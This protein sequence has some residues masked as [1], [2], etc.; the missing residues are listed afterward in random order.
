MFAV[1]ETF[2]CRPQVGPGKTVS[3]QIGQKGPGFK[4]KKAHPKMRLLTCI[5]VLLGCTWRADAVMANVNV[6]QLDSLI[7]GHP[8]VLVEFTNFCTFS[9]I[10]N[11]D[12]D[13]EFRFTAGYTQHMIDLERDV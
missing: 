6:G 1:F 7:A 5:V 11:L 10:V 2:C 9:F 3:V 4:R 13:L 8:L 12:A